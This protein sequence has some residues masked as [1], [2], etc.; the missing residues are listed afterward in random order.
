MLTNGTKTRIMG[1]KETKEGD[2][3][4]G[5]YLEETKKDAVEV[6][7]LLKGIPDNKKEGVLMLVRGYKLGL[8]S[9]DQQAAAG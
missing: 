4:D 9:E 2:L 3:V 7:E 8:E 1:S 6:V 5:T